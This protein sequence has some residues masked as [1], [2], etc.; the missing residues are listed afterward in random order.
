VIVTE[1]YEGQGLGNQL[2]TYAVLRST[3]IALGYEYGIQSPGRFKGQGFINLDPGKKVYGLPSSAPSRLKPF[4]VKNIHQE[5]RLLHK[6]EGFDITTQDASMKDLPDRTK[7][8]GYFQAEDYLLEFKEK[9]RSWFQHKN[10]TSTPTNICYIHIRGGDFVGSKNLLLGANYYRS[11]MFKMNQLHP[12]IDFRILTNDTLLA[13]EYLPTIPIE[14]RYVDGEIESGPSINLDDRIGIDFNKLQHAR[15]LIL[16]N[17]S[18]SWWAAW[19]NRN[20]D[21][22]IAPKYW[23]RHNSSTGFWS[24]GDSLTR[25]WKWLDRGDVLSSYEDC[26]SELDSF[27]SSQEYKREV[28]VQQ[29]WITKPSRMSMKSLAYRAIFR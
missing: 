16:S 9:I 11:A 28:L 27:T 1:F 6:S 29:D 8:Y 2:W 4:G 23:A 14:S 13:R 5:P 10:P 21:L 18:F 22:V 3:A 19:T 24:L 7:I 15:Y 12:G 25:E 26:R 20:A 17:S